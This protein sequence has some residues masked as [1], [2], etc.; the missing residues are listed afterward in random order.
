VGTLT[1]TCNMICTIS[2]LCCWWR[3]CVCF[4]LSVYWVL[5]CWVCFGFCVDAEVVTVIMPR[6]GVC[7]V[8]VVWG[9]PVNLVRAIFLGGFSCNLGFWG[10]FY[11]GG[12][13]LRLR[14][15]MAKEERYWKLTC[16]RVVIND[17]GLFHLNLKTKTV[18]GR[19]LNGV[20]VWNASL[21]S[22]EDRPTWIQVAV[23]ENKPGN[24][25]WQV[26]QCRVR[27]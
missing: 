5:S 8:V 26:P 6:V 1:A 13:D 24:V 22:D 3:S 16:R 12:I 19:H 25:T 27:P 2:W 9:G 17:K 23:S 4:P 20:H 10:W 21:T 14:R 18:V 11:V 15:E 7:C